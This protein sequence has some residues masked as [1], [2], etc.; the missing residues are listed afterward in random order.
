MTTSQWR[1]FR[2]Y[3]FLTKH[4]PNIE[5][6][7]LDMEVHESNIYFREVS[8]CNYSPNALLELTSNQL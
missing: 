3:Q 6:K 1:T 5:K 2:G 8:R 7:L 4:V